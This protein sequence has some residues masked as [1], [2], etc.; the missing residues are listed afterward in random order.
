MIGVYEIKCYYHNAYLLILVY[1]QYIAYTSE[2]PLSNVIIIS[3]VF[4][5]I[6]GLL[7]FLEKFM[8]TVGTKENGEDITIERVAIAI[9]KIASFINDIKVKSKRL[10]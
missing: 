2:L 5:T 8:K 9:C 4:G 3:F 7:S 6:N 1:R 10:L